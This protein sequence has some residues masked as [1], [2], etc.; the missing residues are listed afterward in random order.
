MRSGTGNSILP[1]TVASEKTEQWQTINRTDSMLGIS[2][3]ARWF[4]F[5]TDDEMWPWIYGILHGEPTPAGEFLRCLAL[6][7]ARADSI[8]HAFLRPALVQ[9]KER[10]PKY[11]CKCAA[12]RGQ[13][14]PL[15]SS[16]EPA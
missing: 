7:V 14:V 15:P 9:I 8:A 11:Q 13:Q 10:F 4:M 6:A 12:E 2:Y 3:Q 16:R 1:T 5:Q